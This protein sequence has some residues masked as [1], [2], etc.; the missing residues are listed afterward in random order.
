MSFE[1]A[2]PATP[3]FFLLSPGVDPLLSVRSIGAPADKTEANGLF[4]SVSLGQGQ[5]PGAEK[6]LDRMQTSGGWV[7]LQNIELVARW[8]PKLE[9]KLEALV[10]GAHPEFRVF[11]SSLP[12]NVVPTQILQ[13]S[14]KLTNEPPSGL[15]PNMLRA[16]GTFTEAVWESCP[17]QGELKVIIFALAFFHSVVCERRQFGAIGWNRPYPFNPG[18]LSA[19]I[20]VAQNF[21]NDAP[22]VP[23]DDLQYIF[24]ELMYGGHITD[25]LDRRLCAAYLAEYMTEKLL[26]GYALCP[27]FEVPSPAFS[28]KQF[29]E[30]VD[31]TLTNESPLCY[32]LHANSEINFMTAQA[33]SLFKA[34][35]ELAPRGGG[36]TGGMTMQEKVKR[37]LDDIMERLPELFPLN[38][39]DERTQ[40][41]RTPYTSVFLQECERMNRLLF[42]MRRSLVEL[43]L[44]M[45]DA[46]EN[47][48]NQLYDNK[49]PSNWNKVAY[50]SMR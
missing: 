31:E 34:A 12:Q 25:D 17:K 27:K 7:M 46:M 48:M 20:I 28:H 21:L 40:D 8:L 24:G 18:D 23:W 41:E 39:L 37:I 47:L 10:E 44:G 16:Y 42:E 19:C 2:S 6:A 22:K 33:T 26:D 29:V 15:R 49:V 43:D 9:K 36:G 1:D 13:N 14:I 11:L 35:A 50:P 38:E 32:G 30:Y 45:S 4:F 3:I 5:E